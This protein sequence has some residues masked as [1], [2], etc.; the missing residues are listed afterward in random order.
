M[1]PPTK[2]SHP[3]SARLASD[4]IGE[5]WDLVKRL[6]ELGAWISFPLAVGLAL[7]RG[8][9]HPVDPRGLD[10]RVDRQWE[11]PERRF[12]HQ[13]CLPGGVVDSRKGQTPFSNFSVR[14]PLS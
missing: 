7:L 11:P 8:S 5:H 1:T 2:S 9:K 6:V 3:P 4:V 10:D 13:F 14:N 12:G